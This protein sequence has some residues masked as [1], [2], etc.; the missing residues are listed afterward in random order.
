MEEYKRGEHVSW[1]PDQE[2]E[3]WKKRDVVLVGERTRLTRKR[4]RK[5]RL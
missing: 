1:D 4:I 5:N 3:M 2:I